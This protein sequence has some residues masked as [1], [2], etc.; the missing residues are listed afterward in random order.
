MN[1]AIEEVSSLRRR[2]RIEIPAD[3]VNAEFSKITSDFQKIAQIKGFRAGKAPLSVV[4]KRYAKDIEEEVRRKL[5]PDAFREAVRQKKLQ[6]VNVPGVEDVNPAQKGSTFSFSTVVDLAP[7]F[8]LPEYKGI[9]VKKTDVTV[10][11][12]DINQ[13]ID[14]IREQRADYRTVD[15]AIQKDDYVIIT[16]TGKVDGQPIEEIVPAVPQLGKQEKFWIWI[17]DNIFLPGFG[18][19]LI[20]AKAG[21]DRSV[22]V[23][24]PDDF[25]QEA[26][27]GKKGQYEVKV[28]D[29]R[30]KILPE[31]DDAL[32]QELAQVPL[33]ELKERIRVNVQ[34]DKER[35]ARNDHAKQIFEFLRSKTQF[36]LPESA[37][38]N[39]TQRALYDIVRENQQRGISEQLLE[40][41]KE[42]IFNAAQ[43][44]ARDRVKLG[45]II[46]K[47]AAA[48]KI[49]VSGEE[50]NAEI[51]F[52][53]AQ[54]GMTVEKLVKRLQENNSVE[55]VEE[56]ILNRKTL[57]FL[58]QS[59]TME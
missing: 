28:E 25:A 47:I 36:E 14:R 33:A 37:V 4:E 27:R 12:V 59:A 38:Q 32:A 9:K 24:F 50:F 29:V 6:V 46:N 43:T 16:Y 15:R 13:V 21:E 53:A 3:R 42:D 39:E 40:E 48:E 5:V 55:K 19:Q 11:D 35:S 31:L 18:D 30:E 51:Q 44:T 52:L 1:I 41:K 34:A 2:L 10:T 7:D 17:K 58:L 49:E 57:D 56:D 20:G 23:T 54:Y 8:S 45:F 26:L 22:S